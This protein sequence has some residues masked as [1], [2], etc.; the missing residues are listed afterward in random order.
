MIEVNG[1]L[2]Q[3]YHQLVKDFF[4]HRIGNQELLDKYH[5]S[6]YEK[7]VFKIRLGH[8]FA[9][10]IF[11]FFGFFD[12]FTLP[13]RLLFN[14]LTIIRLVVVLGVM[15]PFFILTFHKYFH[16]Y[17]RLSLF[18][19]YL[20]FGS[21]IIYTST[22]LDLSQVSFFHNYLGLNLTI[23]G[24]FL[25]LTYKVQDTIALVLALIVGYNV[26]NI[27]SN[28]GLF[29]ADELIIGDLIDVNVWLLSVAFLG[30]LIWRYNEN[31]SR[32][33]FIIQT[34]LEKQQTELKEA[35]NVK[36]KFFSV[37]THDLK[38]L[39]SSQYSLASFMLEK[40]D[41]MDDSKKE[42]FVTMYRD[43]SKKTLDVFGELMMWVH[44]Q[45]NKIVVSPE[46]INVSEILNE[47]VDLL[48][49]SI[50]EKDIDLKDNTEKGLI[51][52]CD[53]N[54]IKT[55]LRNLIGNAIKFSNKDGI[56]DINSIQHKLYVEFCITDYGVGMDPAISK[57]LFEIGESVSM[58]GTNGEEGTGL[59]LVLCKE[60]IDLN[61]GKIWVESVK[62]QGTSVFFTL[63]KYHVE[64]IKHDA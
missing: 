24:L 36:N 41:V 6:Q 1:S 23:I 3:Q 31:L 4:S 58:P 40:N 45:T 25:I 48:K 11:L 20:I 19:T 50:K 35:T 12:Y 7:Q 56:I 63:P 57:L 2:A 29:G 22:L 59:G 39:I 38:N 52:Y 27:Y 18:V 53:E 30:Y 37:V 42:E 34:S 5:S 8:I 16:K 14:H 46:S 32:E 55:I 9:S 64:Q 61:G 43:S 15:L 54:T 10:F 21:F 44:I 17:I 62:G 33:N 28:K 51:V 49:I 47:M 60:L 13:N 26:A